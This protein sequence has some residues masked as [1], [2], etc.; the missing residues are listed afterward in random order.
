MESV[1]AERVA[2]GLVE[3]GVD[4]I[5]CR[6]RRGRKASGIG[7]DG[8]YRAVDLG[9]VDL[10]ERNRKGLECRGRERLLIPEA[11]GEPLKASEL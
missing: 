7:K 4:D 11:V 9:F 3:A 6:R 2:S 5:C 1:R 8:N 10:Q